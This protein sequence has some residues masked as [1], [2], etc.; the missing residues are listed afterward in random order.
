VF[1]APGGPDCAASYYIDAGPP[2]V[3]DDR[4]LLEFGQ[5]W[6]A[7]GNGFYALVDALGDRDDGS[8]GTTVSGSITESS[9]P[10]GL[11]D[12]KVLVHTS[13]ALTRAFDLDTD[14]PVFGH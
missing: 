13:N 10:N 9:R 6:T 2:C 8:F 4:I 11:A 3:G 1:T 14:E 12:D 5:L 7:P